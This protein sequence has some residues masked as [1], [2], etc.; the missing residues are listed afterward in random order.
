[1][2]IYNLKS[3]NRERLI[4]YRDVSKLKN[5]EN[6]YSVKK[7]KDVVSIFVVPPNFLDEIEIEINAILYNNVVKGSSKVDYLKIFN[8]EISAGPKEYLSDDFQV[9]FTIRVDESIYS[10][11][12][13]ANINSKV[14]GLKVYRISNGY[15]LA[16]QPQ[17]TKELT[18]G[19]ITL[20]GKDKEKMLNEDLLRKEKKEWFWR[21]IIGICLVLAIAIFSDVLKELGNLIISNVFKII[22]EGLKLNGGSKWF[23]RIYNK[24]I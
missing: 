13:I 24:K 10:N 16:G 22:E 15:I 19:D 11:M 4:E 3:K 8:S 7:I 12:D 18:F 17:I 21:I 14:N 6:Y 1:M 20:S 23:F 5:P 2:G 9:R